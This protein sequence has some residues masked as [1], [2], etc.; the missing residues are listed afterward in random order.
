M[1][2]WSPCS[3]H[4]PRWDDQDNELCVGIIGDDKDDELRVGNLWE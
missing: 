1:Y 2:N 4:F 3:A